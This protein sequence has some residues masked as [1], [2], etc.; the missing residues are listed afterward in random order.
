L[1]VK[2]DETEVGNLGVVAISQSPT[3]VQA[4]AKLAEGHWQVELKP[5]GAGTAPVKVEAEDNLGAR[6]T[7]IFDVTVTQPATV[8]PAANPPTAPPPIVVPPPP[9]GLTPESALATFRRLIADLKSKR[10]PKSTLVSFASEEIDRLR[11]AVLKEGE[12]PRS[13][14]WRKTFQQ[15]VTERNDLISSL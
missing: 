9:A 11:K 13:E 4:A 1:A 7:N 12:D 14:K 10:T 6:A 2:D 5:L 3:V 8:T 15:M